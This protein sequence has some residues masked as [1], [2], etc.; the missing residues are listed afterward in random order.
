MAQA[1]KPETKFAQTAP[2]GELLAGHDTALGIAAVK[3]AT[4]ACPR[5]KTHPPERLASWSRDSKIRHESD[6]AR[7]IAV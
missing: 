1:K 2:Y 6:L 7:R 4:A 3:A 5:G